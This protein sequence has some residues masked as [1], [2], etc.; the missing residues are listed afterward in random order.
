MAII[1]SE[2][3]KTSLHD[4]IAHEL[5]NSHIYVFVSAFLKNMGLENLGKMFYG[6]YEEEQK[7]M[8]EI[9]NLLTDLG[10]PVIIPTIEQVDFPINT[11]E[12]I[13][14]K[15]YERESIT[16]ENLDDLKGLAVDEENG[17]VEEFLRKMVDKQR[18]EM[19][20]A[21]TFRDKSK[22]TGNDWKLVFLWDLSEGK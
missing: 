14:N 22:L 1:I 15:F 3:L 11:I 2:S 20:E 17:I 4:Q 5:L 16:T 9:V 18:A 12:D 10:T 13:A 6:Q 8:Q 19:E 21:I 7:H